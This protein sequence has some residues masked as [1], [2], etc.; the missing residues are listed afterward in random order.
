M[1]KEE[2]E[3]IEE[4]EQLQKEEIEILQRVE[5]EEQERERLDREEN[6]YW[7]EYSHH[8]YDLMLAENDRESL[9]CQQLYTQTQL[10]R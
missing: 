6:R 4:L 10:E 3:L 5:E 8:R 1:Q 9:E 2:K 7:R